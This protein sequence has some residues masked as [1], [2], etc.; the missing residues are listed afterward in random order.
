MLS[1]ERVPVAVLVSGNGSNLEQL[2]LAQ[3]EGRL[4]DG[5]LVLVIAN[6]AGAYALTRAENHGVAARLIPHQGRSREEFEAQLQ[7]ALSQARVKLIVLAGFLRILSGDFVA[8]WPGRIINIHPALL[9]NFG[10]PGMHGLAVHQ[11]VL[12]SGEKCSGATV[13]IVTEETDGGPV[14]L[15]KQVAVAAGDTAQDLQQRVLQQAEWVILPQAVQL[16]CRRIRE[17]TT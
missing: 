11:A 7:A 15:Q 10:G 16:M 12:D 9:P 1:Q 13:H 2:L 6:R 17:E 3:E 8:R 4:P 14:L 5:E